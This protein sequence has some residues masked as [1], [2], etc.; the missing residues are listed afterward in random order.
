MGAVEAV[1]YGSL[2]WDL[3]EHGSQRAAYFFR[4]HCAEYYSNTWAGGSRRGRF[5]SL[6]IQLKFVNVSPEARTS[7]VSMRDDRKL[8]KSFSDGL[9]VEETRLL[10]RKSQGCRL[11]H[12]QAEYSLV[13]PADQAT[14]RHNLTQIEGAARHLW[15]SWRWPE[16]WTKCIQWPSKHCKPDA[17]Q[18]ADT[19]E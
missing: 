7:E 5:S 10:E 17:C 16:T 19:L 9:P 18:W 15:R 8:W 3:G 2:F 4:G 14:L 6:I 11:S 13:G 12:P 1:G